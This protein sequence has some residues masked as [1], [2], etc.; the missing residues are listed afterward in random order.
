M[1]LGQQLLP[2]GN[3]VLEIPQHLLKLFA[4]TIQLTCGNVGGI[5]HGFRGVP[6]FLRGLAH[7]VEFVFL[8]RPECGTP[9]P[10]T[11]GLVMQ[12]HE[13]LIALPQL[14]KQHVC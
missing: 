5:P 14:F 11:H 7:I 13:T 10:V 3:T 1:R 12:L 6:E 4:G 8:L 9:I 2:G